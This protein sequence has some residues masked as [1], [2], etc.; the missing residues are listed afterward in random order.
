[1]D[2][3]Q[4]DLAHY[5]AYSPF[6]PPADLASGTL[7]IDTD[8]NYRISSDRKP[9]LAIKGLIRLDKIAVNLKSGQPLLKL[10]S[11]QARASGLEIFAQ[12]FLFDAILLEGMELFVSR[13]NRGEW[14]YSRLLPPATKGEQKAAAVSDRKPESNK[15]GAPLLV[16]VATFAFKDGSVHFR[17]ALPA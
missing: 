2:L 5:V 8:V 17:D 16:Q 4:L 11:F 12:R 6:K 3:K 10:H 9:E 15:K 13:D 1:I 7:T 14:M